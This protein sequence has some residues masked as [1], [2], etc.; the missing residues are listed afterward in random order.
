MG[1]LEN[2]HTIRIIF[3]K[4]FTISKFIFMYMYDDFSVQIVVCYDI[5]Q[6]TSGRMYLCSYSLPSISGGH[7]SSKNLPHSCPVTTLWWRHNG[8]DGVSNQQ[9]HD[10][11]LN[12]LFRRRSKKTLKLRVT[13]LWVGMSGEFTGDQWF[14][15]QMASNAENVSIGWRHHDHVTI[16]HVNST[17]HQVCN[18]TQLAAVTGFELNLTLYAV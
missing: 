2:I 6:M 5:R 17:G 15:A 3:E 14:P 10:C 1:F 7:L 8:R 11:L 9:P 16:P 13:G 4:K 18:W 12:R